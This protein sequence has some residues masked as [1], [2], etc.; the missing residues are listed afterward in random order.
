[1]KTH[2]AF[3]LS[4]LLAMIAGEGSA[5]ATIVDPVND[6]LPTYAFTKKADLDVVS[7]DVAYNQAAGTFMF[8]GTMNGAI[9]TTPMSTDTYVFGLDRGQGTAGL[10]AIA[11][12]VLFDSVLLLNVNGSGAFIDIAQ[13]GT[14]V[15][16]PRGSVHSSGNTISATF[17]ASLIPSL[18]VRA[19]DQY[20]WNLWPRFAPNV[21]DNTY[22]SDFAPNNSNAPVR[23]VPEPATA[24][25]LALGVGAILLAFRRSR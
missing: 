3:A 13:G 16:L 11:S 8:E 15:T 2:F 7:A 18:G 23:S 14:S 20:T 5:L 24:Y 19:P 9:D 1:M 12:N 4:T 17:S 6:F 21:G 25:L 10:A 22:V